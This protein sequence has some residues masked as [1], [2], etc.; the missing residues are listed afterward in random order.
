MKNILATFTMSSLTLLV[1]AQAYTPVDDGS[2]VKFV[3][4]NLGIN[5]GGTFGGLEGTIN[6]NPGDPTTANF[7]VSVDAQTV[8]TDIESR[9]NHLRKEEYLNVEKYPKINFKSSKVTKTNSADFLFMFGNITIK[10]VSKEVKF[11]FKVTPKNDGYFF[12]GNFKLNRRDFGVGG[13]SLSLSDE[14]TVTLSVFAK[15]N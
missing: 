10:G 13:N 4:K 11:P 3:I 7:D 14:L 5:T 2:K 12:E 8:D 6:F 9:D 1:F 15:K